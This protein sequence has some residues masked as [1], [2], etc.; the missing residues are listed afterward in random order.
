MLPGIT[1]FLAVGILLGIAYRRYSL[2]ASDPWILVCLLLAGLALRLYLGADLYLHPWDERYHALVAKHL[3]DHPF[4]P[5][6][7]DN[8]V[9]PYDYRGW[10]SNHIWLHKQPLPLW[11]LA[12]SMQVFGVHEWAVRVPGILLTA[13][14]IWLMFRIGQML[15]NREVGYLSAGLYAIHGLI[16]ELAGGRVA[17]DH[18]DECPGLFPDARSLF[19]ARQAMDSNDRV[20]KGAALVGAGR[21][22]RTPGALFPEAN[23]GFHPGRPLPGLATVYRRV[24]PAHPTPASTG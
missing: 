7:Y 14:G 17:T 6:L 10:A 5:M 12:G 21:P 20:A 18:A 2:N 9:L 24:R 16:I 15:F 1:T 19:P 23:Q 13:V 22:D 11:L 4:R 8:P 3:M